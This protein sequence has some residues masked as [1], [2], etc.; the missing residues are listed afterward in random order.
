[1]SRE[2]KLLHKTTSENSN[3]QGWVYFHKFHSKWQVPFGT[4]YLKG[5]TYDTILTTFYPGKTGV[6]PV[7]NT[8][9]LILTSIK[10]FVQIILILCNFLFFWLRQGDRACYINIF[11]TE[12]RNYRNTEIYFSVSPSFRASVVISQKKIKNFNKNI[13]F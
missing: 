3:N 4:K 2:G 10:Y 5:E 11:T 12:A 6:S 1:M 7:C 13:V 8:I 9:L